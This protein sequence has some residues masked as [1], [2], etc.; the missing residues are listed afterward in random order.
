MLGQ[1][2]CVV[3]PIPKKG[4]CGLIASQFYGHGA[5][6]ILEWDGPINGTMLWSHGVTMSRYIGFHF[7]CKGKANTAIKHL[8]ETV[9]ETENLHEVHRFSNCR[10]AAVSV[11]PWAPEFG[12]RIGFPPPEKNEL[13]L[14][15]K[16]GCADTVPFQS[17]PNTPF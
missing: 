16:M 3:N 13:V 9:Y 10:G 11:D 8:S 1:V 6:T 15:I 14:S 4:Q 12:G 2:G 5:A 7:D 17:K